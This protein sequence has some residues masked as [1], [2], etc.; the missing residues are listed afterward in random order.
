[1]FMENETFTLNAETDGYIRKRG[2]IN[3]YTTQ[4]CELLSN[5]HYNPISS[6][7]NLNKMLFG[8]TI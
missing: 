2:L 6:G 1:M 3:D 7:F 4:Q 5:T 8:I